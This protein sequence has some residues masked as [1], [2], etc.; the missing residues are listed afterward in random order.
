MAVSVVFDN[1][2]IMAQPGQQSHCDVQVLNTGRVVDRVALD[3]LG[4]A[5][6][7]ASVEPAELSL[8]PGAAG[9][10]RV[11]FS[12]PRAARPQAGEL[13]FA[14]RA[15]SR[16]DPDGSS[17]VE[18]TVTLA[19]FA[20]IKAELVPRTS[21][22]R[23][24]GQ[25]RLIVENLG[26]AGADLGMSAADADDALEFRLRPELLFVEAGTAAFVRVRADPRKRFLKGPSK[27][28][29]FQVYVTGGGTETVTLDGAVLQSQIMP[30]WLLPLVSV[31]VVAVTAL[32]ALWFLLL[33]PQVQSAAVN[34]VQAQT[35]TLASTAAKASQAAARADKAAASANEVAG[36]GQAAAAARARS[37]AAARPAASARAGTALAPVPVST[38][39]PCDAPAGKTATVGYKLTSNQTLDV[40]DVLLENP[41]GNNGTMNIQ[42]GGSPLFE[43]ALADFR[44]LDYHFVQPL[45]FT[46]RRPL[47]IVVACASGAV[48]CTPALSF[49]G[50][51]ITVTPPKRR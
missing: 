35:R 23:R 1:A 20:G 40:S 27:S 13:P 11:I 17:I 26:N 37:S 16:E 7:W 28:L 12:P 18:G 44:D 22:A 2:S 9:S 10:A 41:A 6:G 14:L 36:S 5:R 39:M 51:I 48:K 31:C 50:T 15:Y 46:A 34:A 42:S 47:V 3:V 33:K 21:H 8:M 45:V 4:D 30:G 38:L 32:T 24:H 49:S 25:H 43:F 29:P 19:P